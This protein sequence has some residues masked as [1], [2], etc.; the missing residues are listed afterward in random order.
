MAVLLALSKGE[1]TFLA[2]REWVEGP[3]D[4][5]RKSSRDLLY[6][7]AV[8]VPDLYAEFQSQSERQPDLLTRCHQLQEDLH[9]WRKPWIESEYP[10]V[11]QYPETPS[12]LPHPS[13]FPTNDFSYMVIDY[14]A[15]LLLLTYMTAH[16]VPHFSPNALT[17]QQTVSILRTE[18]QTILTL[19]CFGRAM[20]DIIGITE[21]RCHSLFPLWVLSRTRPVLDVTTTCGSAEEWWSGLYGLCGRLNYGIN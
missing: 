10:N 2:R 8:N 9:T 21:G 1:R 20:S 17:L 5:N 14:L 3:W 16:I 7:I 18:L 6:D 19:P 12:Y 15:F 13:L 11:P 4:E